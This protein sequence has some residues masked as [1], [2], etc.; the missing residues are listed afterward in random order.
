M[1]PNGHGG[2]SGRELWR[3]VLVCVLSVAMA[4]CGWPTAALAEAF[5]E[6]P[7]IGVT[8]ADESINEQTTL[9]PSESQNAVDAA[10]EDV[11]ASE[12]GEPEPEGG[13]MALVCL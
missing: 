3:A 8:A 9:A 7:S 10:G 11:P 13:A 6:M 5:D 12:S 2:A 4:T 1:A